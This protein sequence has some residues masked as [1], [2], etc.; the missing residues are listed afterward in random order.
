MFPPVETAREDAT[1][2]F[3]G[4]VLSIADVP[5]GNEPSLGEKVVTLAVVRSWKGLERDERIAVY[6]N[7]ESAA[8]GYNFA[9]D[10]S[11][12]VYARNADDQKLHV[13][14]CSR[15]KPLADA[16]EDLTFLGAG[17]TPVKVEP[18]A[19][20]PAD[21]SPAAASAT[22]AAP[23]AKKKGCSVVVVGDSGRA[24][25]STWLLATFALVL[26]ARRRRAVR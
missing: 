4:R 13:S 20:K 18:K 7:G 3:E 16:S 24:G 5:A 11:Y 26:G 6:T 9:K 2:V 14:S 10:T 8:C 1:A 23:A 15:T 21:A 25:A 19:I 17:S 22:P 12:L